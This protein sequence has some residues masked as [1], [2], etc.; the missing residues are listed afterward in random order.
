MNQDQAH[1]D[2]LDKLRRVLDVA[3]TNGNQLFI[4]NI[5]REIT[6]LEQGQPSPIVEEYLTAD[7]RDLH[8]V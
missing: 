1:Q 5:E 2:Q 7:E 3:K 4:E 6:A 8:G